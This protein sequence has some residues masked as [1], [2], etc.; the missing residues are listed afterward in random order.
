[1]S[2]VLPPDSA[3]FVG[4]LG[5]GPHRSSLSQIGRKAA[6]ALAD[7]PGR[8]LSLTMDPEGR[9]HLE[10]PEEAAEVDIVGTY[11]GPSDGWLVLGLQI[12]RDLRHEIKQRKGVKT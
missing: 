3:T 7:V 4:R 10:A 1:M 2:A 12:V 5:R 9:V 11:R 6:L 8:T